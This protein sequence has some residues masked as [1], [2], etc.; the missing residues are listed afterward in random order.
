[1]HFISIKTNHL[2]SS[3]NGK[4]HECLEK[5]NLQKMG[6]RKWEKDID[7]KSNK[8]EMTGLTEAPESIVLSS[9]IPFFLDSISHN[10]QKRN[11]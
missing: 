5:K 8:K 4:D 11:S 9:W 3:I 6:I 2:I 1:M 7:M 10:K